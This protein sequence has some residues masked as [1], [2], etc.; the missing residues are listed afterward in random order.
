MISVLI[1]TFNRE[2]QL[3]RCLDS[4]PSSHLISE[5]LVIDNN[6]DCNLCWVEKDY[7]NTKLIKLNKNYGCSVA[8]NIGIVNCKEDLIYF[9]DDDGWI[10]ENTIESSFN[11]IKSH[12]GVGIVVSRILSPENEDLGIKGESRYVKNYNGGASLIKKDI[13]TS[14]SFYPSYKRQM[15]ESY[16]SLMLHEKKIKIFFNQKSL[17]MHEKLKSNQDNIEEYY[18]NIR[19]DMKNIN[20]LLY[21]PINKVLILIK[22]VK[23]V[24]SF[25]NFNIFLKVTRETIKVLFSLDRFDKKISLSSYLSFINDVD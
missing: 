9:L 11:F 15:E 10:D 4:I 12:K 3:K 22:Y 14:I 1:I 19:N 16:I 21:F 7:N 18:Y 17:M 13:F 24:L 5:V 2:Q 23:Y 8:R 25:K 6:S 20:T